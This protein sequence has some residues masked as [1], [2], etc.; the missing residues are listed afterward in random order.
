[1][2]GKSIPKASA[3]QQPSAAVLTPLQPLLAEFADV[4]PES[5][6]LGLP[7]V[8]ETVWNRRNCANSSMCI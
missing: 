1:M 8:R 5:L 2:N 7:V 4:F 6:P 3:Q